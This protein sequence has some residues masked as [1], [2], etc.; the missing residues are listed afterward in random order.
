MKIIE[1]SGWCLVI[2]SIIVLLYAI[3]LTNRMVDML[4]DSITEIEDDQNSSIKE[5]RK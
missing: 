3:W 1:L 5:T 4:P 2:P